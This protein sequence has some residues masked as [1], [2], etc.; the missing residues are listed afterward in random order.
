MTTVVRREPFHLDLPDW[1]TQWLDERGFADRLWTGPAPMRVEE[2][3]DDGT[4]VL[5]AE[6]PGM[7]PD[8]DVE[9]TV[10]DGLLHVRAERTENKED[11]DKAGFRTEFRYGRFE[12]TMPLPAGADV[13][14]VKA[15]YRDGVLEVRVPCPE[16]RPAVKATV[17]VQRT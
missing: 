15:T 2:L 14:D 17:P 11:R 3:E 9:I 8:K 1:M 10:A 12:R 5:R 7:D 4:Y 6:L 13:D 16:P